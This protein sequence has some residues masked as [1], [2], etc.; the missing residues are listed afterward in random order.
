MPPK[1]TLRE[2]ECNTNSTGNS[3]KKPQEFAN[4]T[5]SNA[6]NSESEL[7]SFSADDDALKQAKAKKPKVKP[8]GSTVIDV[9][10]ESDF[11]ELESSWGL[12]RNVRGEAR[13][14][15]VE[16]QVNTNQRELD[17]QSPDPLRLRTPEPEI[18]AEIRQTSRCHSDQAQD[19]ANTQPLVGQKHNKRTQLPM[20]QLG[21]M[22][23][24]APS[25][26]SLGFPL[27]ED[28]GLFHNTAD[29]ISEAECQGLVQDLNSSIDDFISVIIDSA[30]D[31]AP[32]REGSRLSSLRPRG[33]LSDS[34]HGEGDDAILRFATHNM[35]KFP[36]KQSHFLDVSLHRYLISHLIYYS[37]DGNVVPRRLDNCGQINATYEN[38]KTDETWSIS[39]RWR[40]L[41]AAYIPPENQDTHERNSRVEA[42]YTF[43]VKL[44]NST[45]AIGEDALR[46]LAAEI[47]AK[48]VQIY[49]DANETVLK[50]RRDMISTQVNVVGTGIH[51][52]TGRYPS[53]D[54]QTMSTPWERK[55][56]PREE[57]IGPYQ[58][59]LTKESRH[60][61]VKFIIKPV[62]MTKSIFE[63]VLK[64]QC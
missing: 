51:P 59:G 20:Q 15:D 57:V 28:A 54:P 21:A 47:K 49:D 63:D 56:R 12:E 36:G 25:Q 6:N 5:P 19:A 50:L 34:F 32:R 16:E 26:T 64:A 3:I 22:A 8:R 27:G 42:D 40:S 43:I 7:A 14:G 45:Y 46:P 11:S 55:G 30:D 41:T 1:R 13:M 35:H 37:F 48:L 29:Q 38:I 52:Q 23:A 17:S 61:E 10:Y 58:L 2:S 18:Q 39:Q 31:L 62:V 44:L 24:G 4:V 9:G 60:Q 33:R 53:F